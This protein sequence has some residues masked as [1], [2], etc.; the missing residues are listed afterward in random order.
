MKHSLRAL[1]MA[2]AMSL[3]LPVLAAVDINSADQKTLEKL[4]GI[5]P[6]KAKA[7][8]GYREKSGPFKSKEELKKVDG[9][10]DKLYNAVQNEISVG[11]GAKPAK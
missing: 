4:P 2:L 9:I 8:I 5:G 7:I 1:L 3:S 10:G 11:G 6:A